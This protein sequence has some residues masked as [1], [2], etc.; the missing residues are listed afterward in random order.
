M[1]AQAPQPPTLGGQ[2]TRFKPPA[3]CRVKVDTY[4]KSKYTSVI[5][6]AGGWDWFQ[7]RCAQ[8]PGWCCTGET[9]EAPRQRAAGMCECR[10]RS[11]PGSA[12]PSPTLPA[13]TA[14]RPAPP[15]EL[16]G[17][18]QGVAQRH[19]VSIADVA[20]RW[21]LDRPQVAG[22]IVGARNASH[23][24]DLEKVF[25]F[26]LDAGEA[27]FVGGRGACVGGLGACMGGLTWQRCVPQLVSPLESSRA[28]RRGVAGCC[29]AG[30]PR[31][32]SSPTRSPAHPPTHA[33]AADLAAI[34]KVLAAGTQPTGDCYTW[35]R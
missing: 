21:V 1:P 16:L 25:S 30:V 4:S 22:V 5:R 6:Q 11:P 32:S 12:G 10:C 15:Q 14:A 24:G 3:C 27:C 29:G 19:G 9:C 13:A 7:A 35:E 18:L 17:A 8:G 26:Q 20:V 33:T 34:D 31:P 23:V 2:H 28:C